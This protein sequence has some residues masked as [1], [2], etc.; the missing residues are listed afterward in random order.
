MMGLPCEEKKVVFK[1]RC[2]PGKAALQLCPISLWRW[3]LCAH[4]PCPPVCAVV[5]VEIKPKHRRWSGPGLTA[6]G[7]A[8]NLHITRASQS[9][10]EWSPVR[11]QFIC[12]LQNAFGLFL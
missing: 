9:K 10:P 4:H 1:R 3:Q 12:Q 2:L 7:L 5:F 8:Y 11:I 6:N